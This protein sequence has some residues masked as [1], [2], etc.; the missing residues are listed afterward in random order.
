MS[1]SA[2]DR[3]IALVIGPV[4]LLV[5]F[6]FLL[7]SPKRAEVTKADAALAKAEK[8]RETAVGQLNALTASKASFAADY[9]QLVRLGKAVPDSVDMPSVIVQLASAARGTDIKLGRITVVESGGAAAP[10]A[11]PAPAA[12]APPGEGDG[13]QPAAAGGAPAQSAPGST[14][15]N[16]GESVNEA[17]AATANSAQQTEGAGAADGAGGAAAAPATTPGQCPEGLQCIP[18]EFEFSGQFFD[19]ASFF[20]RLK[21]FV[22][23]KNNRVGVHGRLLTIESLN[24]STDGFPRLLAEVKATVYLSE[25]A[26]EVA[27]AAPAPG[28]AAPAAP[29]PAPASTT[30]STTAPPVA[31]ATP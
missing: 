3:K 5:V 31:A 16:A 8:R 20:H 30:S 11:A 10:A 9:A 21:R 14:A 23:V 24:F 28:Q 13:S 17:N 27:G 26:E 4:V 7:F 15:E 22:H 29:A 25:K 1:L 6:W 19:L 18:L 12:P 2:R